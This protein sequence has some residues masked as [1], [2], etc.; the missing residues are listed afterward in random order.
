MQEIDNGI[1]IKANKVS[2]KKMK[3]REAYCGAWVIWNFQYC[4]TKHKMIK[5]S[6]WTYCYPFTYSTREEARIMLKALKIWNPGR[7]NNA[8]IERS[9]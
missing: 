2:N 7:Y 5:E 6:Y 9:Y 4:I 1:V 3:K 8:R